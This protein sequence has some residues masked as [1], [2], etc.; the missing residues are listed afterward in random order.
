[1]TEEEEQS[2]RRR[3]RIFQF[4]VTMA[5][6]AILYKGLRWLSRLRSS[7][8]KALVAPPP[9]QVHRDLESIFTRTVGSAP[10]RM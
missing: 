6:L 3:V 10:R 2:R 4:I 8:R 9:P 5:A 7:S 1:M